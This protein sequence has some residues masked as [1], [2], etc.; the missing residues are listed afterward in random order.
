MSQNY[1]QSLPQAFE[2]IKQMNLTPGWYSDYRF[3]ARNA[4]ARIPEDRMEDRLD[5][6]LMDMGRSLP[7]RRNGYF[8]RHLLT[9]LGDIQLDVPRTRH[10]SAV[11]VVRAHARR[12][13]QVDRMILA[14][15]VLGLSTRKV[16]HALM[17]VLGARYSAAHTPRDHPIIVILV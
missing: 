2:V 6:Y 11:D 5:R 3:A 9:E 15:F 7:D 17:P 12:V 14:C 8:S 10:W 16:A 1:I 13:D 4:L